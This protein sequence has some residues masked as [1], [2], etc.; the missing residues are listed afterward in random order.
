M[1]YQR[2]LLP[3]TSM[4]AAFDAAARTGSFTDAGRELNLTQGAISRQV[5]ALE[6]QL[7]VILFNRV[8]NTIQLTNAGKIYAREIHAALQAIRKASL[9]AMTDPMIATLN[10]AIL[11]TFG[12]R[13]LMPRFPLFLKENPDITVNFVSKLSPFDFQSEDL[14]AAIHYGSPDWPGT[15]SSFLM[16]EKSVPVCSPEFLSLNPLENTGALTQ[17]PLLHLATRPDAWK[18]W[19]DSNGLELPRAQGMLFEQISIIAQAAVGGLG[20]ALLPKFLIQS[21]LDRGELVIIVDKPLQSDAG[22]HLITPVDKSDYAPIAAFRKW[23]LKMAA[24]QTIGD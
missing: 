21:E 11:P 14:H 5:S 7:D 13:W 12:T 24:Q 22:Y 18:N 9:N 3:S 4:M 8:R 23:I 2:R 17:L 6:N 1:P 19:F 16:S 10:L 20:V 15:N